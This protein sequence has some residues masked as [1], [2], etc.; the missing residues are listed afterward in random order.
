MAG[1]FWTG[2]EVTTGLGRGVGVTVSGV[3]VLGAGVLGPGTTSGSPRSGGA[4]FAPNSAAAAT[5]NPAAP[6]SAN[7]TSLGDKSML[8][9]WRAERDAP[10]RTG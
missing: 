4:A 5:P 10:M 2:F 7:V 6:V 9:L 1:G 8:R 3:G